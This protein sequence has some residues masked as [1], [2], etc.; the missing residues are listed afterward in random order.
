MNENYPRASKYDPDWMKAN[1]MGPNASFLL[2]RLSAHLDLKKGMR[3]LDLG[4]GRGITSVFLAKEFGVQVWAT[5]LWIAASDNYKRFIEAGVSDAVYPI[6]A[7]AHELPY[8]DGFFDAIVSLDAYH[9]FGAE[10]D[11]LDTHAA[12]LLK[13]DGQ[14]GIV[15][16][17]LS[18]ELGKGEIPRGLESYWED[19]FD[20]FHSASWWENL[21]GASPK[22]DVQH[23]E[24]MPDGKKI[25]YE[26]VWQQGEYGSDFDREFLRAD[27]DD[28]MTMVMMTGKRLA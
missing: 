21:W 6:H 10:E 15:V 12:K 13:N 23:I 26:S 4:C 27:A 28:M 17:G 20:T 11:Y 2:E 3:V 5:D 24:D 8:A 1:M 25:W 7:E 19:E 22:I 16:P 9:Y 18:R 14:I